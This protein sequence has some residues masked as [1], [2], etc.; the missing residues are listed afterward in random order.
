M[1]MYSSA[2]TRKGREGCVRR[3]NLSILLITTVPRFSCV[4]FSRPA[5]A[6]SPATPFPGGESFRRRADLIAILLLAWF[7]WQALSAST[8]WSHTSDELAHVTAGYAYDHFGDYRLQPENGILPQR[9]HGLAPLAV[10]AQ[11]PKDDLLWQHSQ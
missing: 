7:A 5:S 6:S 8:Q 10:G 1:L 3:R 2:F 9:V 11:F 4:L